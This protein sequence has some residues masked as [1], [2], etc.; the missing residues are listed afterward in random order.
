[1]SACEDLP[2]NAR[3]AIQPVTCLS[4]LRRCRDACGPATDL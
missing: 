3:H 4:R 2:A 1:L